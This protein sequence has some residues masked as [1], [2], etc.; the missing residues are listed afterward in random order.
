R[1]RSRTGR[2]K[3][4]KQYDVVVYRGRFQGMHE[5]HLKTILMGLQLAKKVVVVI[6]SANEP[7]TYYRNPFFENERIDMIR[8]ALSDHF[9][10]DDVVFTTVEDHPDDNVW[11]EMVAENVQ[12][13]IDA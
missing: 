1:R 10:H 2:V 6:G 4:S 3:M 9:R 8:A 11:A 5:A 12:I 13:M 7:R